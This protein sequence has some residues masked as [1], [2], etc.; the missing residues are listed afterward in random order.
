ML[1][2]KNK[3]SFKGYKAKDDATNPAYRGWGAKVTGLSHVSEVNGKSIRTPMSEEEANGYNV[4]KLGSAMLGLM[5][6]DAP[7]V[8]VQI[9]YKRFERD[10]KTGR[11]IRTTETVKDLNMTRWQGGYYYKDADP[12]KSLWIPLGSPEVPAHINEL[13][14]TNQKSKKTKGGWA[15]AEP[16]TESG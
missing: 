14:L 9:K 10:S 8:S 5:L 12:N 13:Q 4:K 7:H 16:Y 3:S 11:G 15:Y 2:L 6:P 1:K